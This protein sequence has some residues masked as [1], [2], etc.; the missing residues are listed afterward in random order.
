MPME[1]EKIM[2]EIYTEN[3]YGKNE[4]RVVYFTE[5]EEHNKEKE[6]SDAMAGEHF[7]DGFIMEFR[8]NEAKAIIAKAVEKLNN[9]ENVDPEELSKELAPYAS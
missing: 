9:G 2:F 6:I 4:Y 8:K 3:K 5:L 7:F 1:S